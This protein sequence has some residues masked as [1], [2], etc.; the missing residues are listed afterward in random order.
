M[1]KNEAEPKNALAIVD[2]IIAA[3]GDASNI[4]KGLSEAG[5]FKP[6]VMLQ[7]VPPAE[8]EEDAEEREPQP[9]P[10]NAPAK[11]KKRMS[12]SE[13]IDLAMAEHSQS[14]PPAPGSY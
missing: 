7:P 3:G 10:E 2:E 4:I 13:A 1:S 8:D 11:P 14:E 6:D 9:P 12:V 5:L